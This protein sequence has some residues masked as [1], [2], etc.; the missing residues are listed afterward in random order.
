[1]VVGIWS[2]TILRIGWSRQRE[3]PHCKDTQA[4]AAARTDRTLQSKVAPSTEGLAEFVAS[5]DSVTSCRGG[6]SPDPASTPIAARSAGSSVLPSSCGAPS[7]T[8]TTQSEHAISRTEHVSQS[9]SMVCSSRHRLAHP[10]GIETHATTTHRQSRLTAILE[11]EV[12]YG[13]A[14]AATPSTGASGHPLSVR[15]Q[16]PLGHSTR[17]RPAG[18]PARPAPGGE[19][20][21][22]RSRPAC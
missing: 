11:A 19:S 7:S 14:G 16:Q 15:P 20:D 17:P 18:Q 13:P 22:R 9:M 2:G 8:D 12:S 1:M 3:P 4:L 10:A 5:A 21:H 6:T